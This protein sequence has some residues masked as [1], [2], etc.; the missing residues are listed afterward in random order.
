MRLNLMMG[1]LLAL[2]VG[3][4]GCGGGGGDSSSF[5][6]AGT[7]SPPPTTDTATGTASS[8]Y[9]ESTL[10]AAN[11]LNPN[12]Y[13]KSSSSGTLFNLNFGTFGTPLLLPNNNE[14][15][16][17]IQN[18]SSASYSFT[19]LDGAVFN[20][21]EPDVF[22]LNYSTLESTLTY[23]EKWITSPLISAWAQGLNGKAVNIAILD[24]FTPNDYSEWEVRRLLN[25]C[26]NLTAGGL[27]SFYC[28]ENQGY[29]YKLTHGDQVSLILSGNQSFID[30]LFYSNGKYANVQAPTVM[31]GRVSMTQPVTVSYS[32]PKYGVAY[33]A[34]LTT[35]RSDYLTYQLNT[36]GLFNQLQLWGDGTDVSSQNYKM[37]Q[38]VNLSLGGTS[39]SPITNKA[40]YSTQ[41]A[42]ANASTVPNAVYVK[43]AGNEAC[44]I[45]QT[46]CDPS[47]AVLYNSANFKNKT[48]IVGAL[49]VSGGSI[50]TYSN[51]AGS[52]SDRFVVADGRGIYSSTDGTYDEGTS[53]SAPRV[54]GYVAILRQKYPQLTASDAASIILS[55]AK[56]NSAWGPKNAT[57]QAIYGQGEAD[58]ARAL[59]AIGS[60]P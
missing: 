43:A 35:K 39:K 23:Q 10:L 50:A 12:G 13:V 46:N 6:G 60:L 19:R 24:D 34:N 36:K 45:S 56:W 41:L 4:A 53:F 55:T 42:Y 18:K 59:S 3:V 25:T 54:A 27:T 33:G 37:T 30:M 2:V 40:T 20:F 52:Y 58:L 31:L 21:T 29:I 5:I 9:L 38:V 15:T 1:L 14:V 47:N 16:Y 32:S 22:S 7:Q 51:R 48:L 17:T 28:T 8:P 44:T 57:S 49:N 11:K 26:F